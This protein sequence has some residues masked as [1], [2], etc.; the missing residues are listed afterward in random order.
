MFG[1]SPVTAFLIPQ[2]DQIV[3]RMIGN[4]WA[5]RTIN[6]RIGAIKRMFEY[7]YKRDLI[8]GEQFTKIKSVPRVKAD[9]PRVKPARIVPAVPVDVVE[10]T[11]PYFPPMIRDIVMVQLK[12]GMRAGE[13]CGM[14]FD[15]LHWDADGILWY[16]PSHHK[17]ASRGKKRS[18][19]LGPKSQEVLAAYGIKPDTPFPTDREYVFDPRDVPRR[20]AAGRFPRV[21]RGRILN[22]I[23]TLA[24]YVMVS[25]ERLRRERL[26]NRN[27]GRAINCGIV[28]VPMRGV[29]SDWM[30]PRCC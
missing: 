30:R 7:A 28:P 4:G 18:I 20:E 9:D 13:V 29:N 8:T 25:T 27:V 26:R 19:L 17:T 6:L 24:K 10:R 14:R 16:C 2:F 12:T 23:G 22:H 21:G 11:L 5:K 1:R 15:A 3:Q